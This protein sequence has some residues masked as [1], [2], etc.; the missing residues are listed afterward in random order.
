[1]AV[2]DWGDANLGLLVLVSVGAAR[3]LYL[4][5]TVS[6]QKK[7]SNDVKHINAH[8]KCTCKNNEKGT[9]KKGVIVKIIWHP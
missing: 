1:M 6:H 5:A 4:T 9:H 2:T 3:P 8:V 7:P